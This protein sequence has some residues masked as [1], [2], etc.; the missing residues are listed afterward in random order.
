MSSAAI[1]LVAVLAVIYGVKHAAEH[2]LGSV[3][4][5]ALAGGLV[6]GALFARRQRSLADPLIDL[7][8]FRVPAFCVALAANTLAIF[9]IS[10]AFLFITQYMQLALGLS[11][12]EAGLWMPPS[13]GAF[14]AGSMLAPVLA[15]RLSAARVVRAGLVLAAAGLFVLTRIDDASSLALLL[16]ASLLMDSGLALVFVLGTD[17][18]VGSAPPERAGAASAISETGAELGGALGIAILGSIG[19]AVYRSEMAGAVP[20]DAPLA[21]AEAARDTLGGAVDAADQLPAGMLDVAVSAFTHGLQIASGLT[22]VLALGV[23]LVS[24]WLLREGPASPVEG[25]V[26]AT[27]AAAGDRARCPGLVVPQES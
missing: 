22:A 5:L 26:A 9:V 1:S 8:L 14:V 20:A 23:A 2:G 12:L 11:A 19:A 6:L 27:G 16:T 13:A 10:G 21:A 4:A 15:R 3:A 24:A 17:L 7:R 18:I 25:A